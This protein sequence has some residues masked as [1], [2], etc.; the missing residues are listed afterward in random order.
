MF[1]ASMCPSSGENYCIHASLVLVTLYGWRLVCWLDWKSNIF[2]YFSS[3][4]VSGI[5]VPITRRK[6]LY[7]CVTGICHTVWVASG[8]LVGL[9]IQYIYLFLFYTRFGHPCAHHQEKNY[10]IHASLVLVTLYGWRLVCWL[11]WKSNIF[12][13]LS[14]LHVS[15]IHVP[16]IRRKL[17]YP[18]VTGTCHTVCVASGLLVGLTSIQPADQAPPI[19]SDKYQWHMD[20]VIF[21]WWWTRGSPKHVEKRNK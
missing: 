8:L 10:C 5:H 12:I 19:Q 3:I 18:C 2:I 15:G 20:T 7:P 13:Y 17:L 21:S 4:H 9:K 16:I 6:L 11:D 14:S 1:W